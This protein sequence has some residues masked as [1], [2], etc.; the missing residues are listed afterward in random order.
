MQKKRF[1]NN[2]SKKLIVL[3][4]FS[5]FGLS[6]VTSGPFWVPKLVPGRSI[7]RA[8]SKNVIFSESRSRC[9]GSTV[10]EGRTLQKSIRRAT[11]NGTGRIASGAVSG[12]TFSLPQPFFVDFRVPAGSQNRPK[13]VPCKSHDDCWSG[14]KLIFLYF[15]RS[16][17]FRKGPGAILEAP[18]TPPEQI[19]RGF[20]NTFLQVA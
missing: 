6:S 14:Q 1:E 10:L 4:F 19:L 12:R 2:S 8:F 18:G 9:G 13:T 5:N 7:F 16:G 15:L 3:Q 11:P 17:V 20:C